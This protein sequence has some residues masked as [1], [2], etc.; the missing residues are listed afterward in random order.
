VITAT[1]TR[2]R[3]A[4]L[5]LPECERTRH[6]SALAALLH[7]LEH[8]TEGRRPLAFVA[9][10]AAYRSPEL[11]WAAALLDHPWTECTAADCKEP[12]R[13]TLTSESV[14]VSAGAGR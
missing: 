8:C 9:G 1:R 2:L 13:V 5:A 12:D 6:L 11:R 3:E 10:R 14:E 4:V 7:L